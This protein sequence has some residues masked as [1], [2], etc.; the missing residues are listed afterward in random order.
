M[1]MAMTFKPIITLLLEYLLLSIALHSWHHP[2]GCSFLNAPPEDAFLEVSFETECIK[3]EIV[4]QWGGGDLHPVSWP[5]VLCPRID[6]L[7][8]V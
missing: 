1:E 6:I 5:M 7:I 4:D 2:S 8:R 3:K